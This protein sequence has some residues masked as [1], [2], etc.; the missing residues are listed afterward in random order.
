MKNKKKRAL[1]KQQIITLQRI[2]RIEQQII[3]L[4][5]IIRIKKEIDDY[6]IEKLK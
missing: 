6:A 2:L 1:K 4:R 5:D 3:T